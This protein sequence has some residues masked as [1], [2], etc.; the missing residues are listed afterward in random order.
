MRKA[1]SAPSEKP[2]NYYGLRGL[3]LTPQKRILAK[4]AVH[5]D[6]LMGACTDINTDTKIVRRHMRALNRLLAQI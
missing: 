5:A 4:M 2:N 6:E 1:K 3:K